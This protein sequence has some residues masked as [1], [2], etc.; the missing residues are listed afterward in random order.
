[1]RRFF[2]FITLAVASGAQ[3]QS[4]G[5]LLAGT[6]TVDLRPTPDAPAYTQS[7]LVVADTS[8]PFQ[9]SFYGSPVQNVVVNQD[10]G[11]LRI[12]FTTSDDSGVYHH[13]AVLDGT[14]LEGT[15]HAVGR[16]FLAV[17]TATREGP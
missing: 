15:T 1:M 10:W 8:A 7:F 12:A 6:W 14:R 5:E 9:G 11:A 17:W 13:V 3:A 2:L 16:G 4:G